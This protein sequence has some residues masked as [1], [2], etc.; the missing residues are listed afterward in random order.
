MK[1]VVEAI[2]TASL[3]IGWSELPRRD[4]WL[5]MALGWLI[6]AFAVSLG[7]PFRFDLLNRFVNVRASGKT[8]EEAPK[9]PREVPV[10]KQP[11]G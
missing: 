7:A 11:G 2:S 3:P 10:P 5:T 1:D 4:Q 9:S 6:T 8:P